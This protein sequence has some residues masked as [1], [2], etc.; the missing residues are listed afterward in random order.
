MRMSCRCCVSSFWQMGVPLA[1]RHVKSSSWQSFEIDRFPNSKPTTLH[2]LGHGFVWLSD[3]PLR[4]RTC[5]DIPGTE[6]LAISAI[7]PELSAL[8]TQIFIHDISSDD[9]TPSDILQ[10]MSAFMVKG[11]SRTMGMVACLLHAYADPDV[12]QAGDGNSV[13]GACLAIV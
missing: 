4:F 3:T 7:G 12:L 10:P 13:C 5:P 1:R 9:N 2:H 11:W 8:Q 6:K